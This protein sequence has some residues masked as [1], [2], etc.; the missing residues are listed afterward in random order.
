MAA[1]EREKIEEIGKVI[2]SGTR[3]RCYR[4]NYL[5]NS[6]YSEVPHNTTYF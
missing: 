2:L 5:E 6:F 3:C 4:R 1:F